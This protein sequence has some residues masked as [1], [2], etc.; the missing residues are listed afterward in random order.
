MYM[1]GG[2]AQG[3]AHKFHRTKV[4]ARRLGR[5]FAGGH[6]RVRKWSVQ[7]YE[8]QLRLAIVCLTLDNKSFRVSKY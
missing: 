7:R 8:I 6:E 2:C 1:F 5:M 4:I 3:C